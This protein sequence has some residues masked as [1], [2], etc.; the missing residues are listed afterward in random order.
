MI[1]KQQDIILIESIL[2]DDHKAQKTFYDKYRTIL[3][4]YIASK[5]PN[6]V[7]LEDDVSEILIKIFTNLYKFDQEKATVKT[8]IFVIAKNYMIDKFRSYNQLTGTITI[9]GMSDTISLANSNEFNT[10][11]VTNF[12]PDEG[13]WHY[14]T[15]FENC[16]AVQFV[17][18]Q[19]ATC[20]FTLLNMKYGEGYNYNE[21]GTEFN[22]SS[23]TIS[24]RVN[25]IK[26]KLKCAL[27]EE[28][29]D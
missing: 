13:Y 23:N 16:D 19:I 1:N 29:N 12:N 21:I 17:S 3:N 7:D 4:D 18:N 6:N 28:L 10:S 26:G 5:Y 8:W 22:V 20:D 11:D 2:K 25:Y 15:E 14:T 24:N 27:I 9:D